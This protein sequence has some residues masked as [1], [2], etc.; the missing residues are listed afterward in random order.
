M[1]LKIVEFRYENRGDFQRIT[2]IA[3]SPRGTKFR[4]EHV[5]VKRVGLDKETFR[6]NRAVAVAQLA[7]ERS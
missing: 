1:R 5:D 6:A 7:A 4:Y 3:A 2:A